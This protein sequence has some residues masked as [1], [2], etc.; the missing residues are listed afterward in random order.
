MAKLLYIEA[1]PRKERSKS[2]F[3][4]KSFLAKYQS[5]HR[6]DEVQTK[7]PRKL[8]LRSELAI[9]AIASNCFLAIAFS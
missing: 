2:I 4:A 6:G 3:V 5:T 9:K 8:R 7:Q 1:S